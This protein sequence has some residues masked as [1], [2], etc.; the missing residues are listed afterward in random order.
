M[1]R[2]GKRAHLTRKILFA[3]FVRA[4]CKNHAPYYDANANRV[5]RFAFTLHA[6][7][8][9]ASL[10]TGTEILTSKINFRSK[11]EIPYTR[12]RGARAT[13]LRITD[14]WTYT[15]GM[16]GLRTNYTEKRY[17]LEFVNEWVRECNILGMC[18]FCYSPLFSYFFHFSS[19]ISVCCFI[20][21]VPIWGFDKE[22]SLSSYLSLKAKKWNNIE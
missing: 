8:A 22:F 5:T 21:I 19:Y 14:L 16:N 13:R 17:A 7:A 1:T 3:I 12:S 20:V 6:A 18:M 9:R 2:Y 15:R 10:E 4:R 11:S